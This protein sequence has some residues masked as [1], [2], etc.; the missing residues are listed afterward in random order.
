MNYVLDEFANLPKIN[1]M[2]ARSRSI[3]FMLI[4]QSLIQL[5]VTYGEHAEVIRLNCPT[6]IFLNSRE[7]KL[8]QE[9]L[10]LCGS[11]YIK[12]RGYRPLMSVSALQ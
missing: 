1:D 12:D 8:L 2:P 6:W 11:V 4:V 7:L 5:E 9:I 3:R 10:E